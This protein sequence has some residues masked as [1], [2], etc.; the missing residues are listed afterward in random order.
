MEVRVLGPVEVDGRPI[1]GREATVLAALAVRAPRA[2]TAE[3]L[4]DD[5][6]GE[7]PPVT[8]PKALQNAISRL[9]RELGADAIET[10]EGGYRL[11][12]DVD[13]QD[14]TRLA[15]AGRAEEALQHWRGVPTAVPDGER[16][17]LAELRA[18]LEDDAVRAC[19]E[20]GETDVA[21]ATLERLVAD[22][23]YREPRW[24]L[25]VRAL[26]A[27]GRQA[28]AL[29][30]AQR[31]R[32]VLADDLGLDP[33]P[34]LRAAERAVLDA[35][36]A[37]APVPTQRT[38]RSRP[39]PS[40]SLVGRDADVALVRQ[41]AAA[42]RLVTL[43]GPGG[44]GKSRLALAALDGRDDVV[45]VD[46]A[47]VRDEHLW[48]AVAAAAG[49][50]TQVGRSVEES[51][52]G[53]I[54]EVIVLLDSCEHVLDAAA[55]V[56]DAL[57]CP[58][59]AT[60]REPL[61]LPDEVVVAIGPLA[62][63]DAVRLFADRTGA[64]TV[65]DDVGA[66]CARLDDLPL[67]IELAAARAPVLD[68]AQM[69][70][71]LDDRFAL[72]DERARRGEARHRGL[73]AMVEWSY[74]L[75]DDDERLLFERLSL[76]RSS[77]LL[78]DAEM[79]ASDDRLPTRL[80][81]PALTRLVRASM[82]T[83]DDRRRFRLLDT[84]RDFG[85]A[86]LDDVDA[87]RS[88]HLAW[89]VA[90]AA[91]AGPELSGPN[92]LAWF[93]RLGTSL[94]DIQEALAW[95]ADHGEPSD[96]LSIAANLFHFWMARARR[97]E[98]LRWLEH[99][100]VAATEVPALERCRALFG[101]CLF[102]ALTDLDAASRVGELATQLAAGDRDATAVADVAASTALLYR[103]ELGAAAP[104]IMRAYEVLDESQHVNTLPSQ[105]DARAWLTIA[106]GD[107]ETGR[108]YWRRTIDELAAMG[109]RHLYSGFLGFDADFAYA[110]GSFDEAAAIARE[111]VAIATEVGCP[112][113]ASSGLA[114]AA[115]AA[116]T[117]RTTRVALLRRAVELAYEINEVLGALWAMRALAG[118]LA[119]IDDRRAPVVLGAVDAE[120]RRRGLLLLAPGRETY[121]AP[122]L[123]AGRDR[124]G[125]DRWDAL[126]VEGELLDYD[127]GVRVALGLE[128]V[129]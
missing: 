16:I 22:D 103:L 83:V 89:V 86:R 67:A 7:S 39:R 25:L 19:L 108:R 37:P 99:F 4:I 64:S 38:R 61:G 79:L 17:R 74:D 55:V 106:Q 121:S 122:R 48:E 85:A 80:V 14:V 54:G 112:S 100:A 29:R 124:M 77:F 125:P 91:A 5:V 18:A 120:R 40:T 42:H 49:V 52:V 11:L 34:E 94:D 41:A 71:R 96:G 73:A 109:D 32:R 101:A 23:P 90:L 126:V 117:D 6:W 51:V 69:V 129:G 35:A 119:D 93:D 27:A 53:A 56:A 10:V 95:C 128:P 127:A 81:A 1:T 114:A 97:S 76:F 115:I 60:S 84:F 2:A 88:R 24:V 57:P 68:P 110:L 107:I 36:P 12:T 123:A 58:V 66:L 102:A 50:G 33:G 118:A 98:G 82:V 21:V 59:M 92:Q 113:C 13:L 47:A 65:G 75:L 78:E 105:W 44:V 116:E 62:R 9:R 111:A 28:D 70:Q 20:R 87:W 30:A 43:V 8:A 63:A 3:Q 45:F 31:A 15:A 104:R 46:L 72:L 26:A